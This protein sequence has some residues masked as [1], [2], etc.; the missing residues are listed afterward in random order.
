MGL[1]F[2]LSVGST[3][4]LG[5]PQL[6]NLLAALAVFTIGIL[7]HMRKVDWENN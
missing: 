2:L 4:I 1:I 3:F 5:L 6:L 7:L